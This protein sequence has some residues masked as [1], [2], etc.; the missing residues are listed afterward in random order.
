M[1]GDIA[2]AESYEDDEDGEVGTGTYVVVGI[3]DDDDTFD[4]TPAYG[5]FDDIQEASD[6]G[7][8]NYSFSWVCEI[9]NR[10]AEE[11]TFHLVHPDQST[12]ADY[13]DPNVVE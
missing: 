6:Y 3:F 8:R 11:P 2:I 5:P 1:M 13:I 4:L 7:T 10:Q 9:V 12:I